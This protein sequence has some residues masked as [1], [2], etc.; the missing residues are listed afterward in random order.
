MLSHKLYVDE[1][2]NLHTIRSTRALPLWGEDTSAPRLN[3]S[4]Q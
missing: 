3:V 1:K 4:A 2:E